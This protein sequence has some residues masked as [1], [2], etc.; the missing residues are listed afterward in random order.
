MAY[1]KRK[2]FAGKTDAA[3]QAF[4]R[5][6][7]LAPKEPLPLAYGS[8]AGRLSDKRR[9]VSDSEKAIRLSPGCAEAHMS[10]TLL[11]RPAASTSKRRPPLSSRDWIIMFA[12][13]DGIGVS[14]V[15]ADVI[16]SMREDD[17]GL[18]YDFKERASPLWVGVRRVNGLPSREHW[19]RRRQADS[20]ACAGLP[21]M[22]ALVA[23]C[24]DGNSS[25]CRGRLP[26][27][28]A[29]LGLAEQ[30]STS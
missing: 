20:V 14:L 18:Q 11:M 30:R 7:A 17:D 24:T 8:W 2:L 21:R 28:T 23:R 1:G 12:D 3:T 26:G 29:A 19:P 16:A 9:A 6:I 10:L 13:A 4:T 25:S 27:S 15:F 5:A 22:A